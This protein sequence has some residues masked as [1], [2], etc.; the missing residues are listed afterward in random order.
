M[1]S[2]LHTLIHSLSQSEK[3]YFK[4]HAGF[5]FPSEEKKFMQLFDMLLKQTI[6]NEKTIQSKLNSL[7]LITQ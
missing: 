1:S 2:E 5:M 7:N 3:R 6:Y 4:L